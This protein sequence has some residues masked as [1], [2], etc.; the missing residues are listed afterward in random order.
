[1]TSQKLLL[2]AISAAMVALAG[3]SS[4]GPQLPE[5]VLMPV[6]VSCPVHV[7]PA[8][9]TAPA[10]LHDGTA[11]DKEKARAIALYLEQRQGRIKALEALLAGS[12]KPDA[13]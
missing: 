10:S 9:P 3:C 4:T 13:K 6:A 7:V 5:R 2:C 8:N 11:R 1:M 12:A